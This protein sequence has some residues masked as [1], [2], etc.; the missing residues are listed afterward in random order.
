MLGDG[1]KVSLTYK[2]RDLGIG[3]IVDSSW[4][5]Y[6]IGIGDDTF[7]VPTSELGNTCI[8]EEVTPEIVIENVIKEVIANMKDVNRALDKLW[9]F[10]RV[11]QAGYIKPSASLYEKYTIKQMAEMLDRVDHGTYQS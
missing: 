9:Y 8:L 1:T 6:V 4:Y 7:T 2:G 11:M 10:K 5:G 3:T